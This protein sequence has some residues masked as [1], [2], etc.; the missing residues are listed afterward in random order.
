MKFS[1]FDSDNDLRDSNCAAF[2]ARGAWW[3]NNCVG[4]NPMGTYGSSGNGGWN[5][6][7]WYTISNNNAPLK[8]IEMKIRQV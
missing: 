7:Y 8:T 1:T 6:V 2:N 5:G 3:Y 4:A